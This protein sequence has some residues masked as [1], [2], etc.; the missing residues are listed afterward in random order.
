MPLGVAYPASVALTCL[1]VIPLSILSLGEPPD[2]VRLAGLVMLL[3]SIAM[4]F[5]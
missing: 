3:V 5:R 1:V 2:A 4:L